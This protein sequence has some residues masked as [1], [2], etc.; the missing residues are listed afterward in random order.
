[1]D[2]LGTKQPIPRAR[3]GFASAR[4]SRGA[5]VPHQA[6]LQDRRLKTRGL[7]CVL[8]AQV[9]EENQVPRLSS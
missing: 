2:I 3:P 4:A 6:A 7:W 1:M 9:S 5:L 8:N